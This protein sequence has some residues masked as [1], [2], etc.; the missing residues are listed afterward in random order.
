MWPSTQFTW[1]CRECIL[2]GCDIF[3][4]S[5]SDHALVLLQVL[6]SL[7]EPRPE[8]FGRSDQFVLDFFLFSSR[9][10]QSVLVW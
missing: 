7:G 8:A 9:H 1:L 6:L 2:Y 5:C 4:V 10:H 3:P